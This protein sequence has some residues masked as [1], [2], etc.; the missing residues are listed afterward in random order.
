MPSSKNKRRIM[1]TFQLDWLSSV[2]SPA[3]K[4]AVAALLKRDPAGQIDLPAPIE[5]E[6]E[7]DFVKRIEALP[8]LPQGVDPWQIAKALYAR[9]AKSAVLT[10]AVDGH[11]HVIVTDHG[12]GPLRHGDTSWSS[13][14]GESAHD[15]HS[16]PWIMAEAGIQVGE[17]H[18]HT[19]GIAAVAAKREQETMSDDLKKKL[20]RL[21]A[22]VKLSPEQRAHF[23]TLDPAVQDVFLGMSESERSQAV[24]KAAKNAAEAD[25][26][27]F[28]S[29]DGTE[30][31]KSD[32]SRLVQMARDRDEDRARTAKAEAASKRAELEKRAQADIPHLPGDEDVRCALLGAVDGIEDEDVRKRAHEAL[33]AG[34]TALGGAFQPA[35]GATT[36]GAPSGGMAKSD[37]EARLDELAKKHQSDKG[38]T[39]EAAYAAVCDTAEGKELLVQA[40]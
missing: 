28:T 29:A 31:R 14:S 32:D 26:V 7:R 4:G 3:Q 38:G 11:S 1:R 12:N 5:G 20:E 23:D 15:G 21:E 18:G 35:P 8:D 34:S 9:M 30:Y 25:P 17:A 37:A 33:S 22:I 6:S 19:H 16:H 10:T 27:V 36:H 39:F 40:S 13:G 24:E 2:D